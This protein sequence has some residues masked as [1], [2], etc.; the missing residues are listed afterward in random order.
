MVFDCSNCN[1]K[2]I[3]V[4]TDKVWNKLVCEDCMFKAISLG[5]R[6]ITDFEIVK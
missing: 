5:V 4:V 3:N 6:F 1:D 2:V